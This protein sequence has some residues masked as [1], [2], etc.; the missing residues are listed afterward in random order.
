M[1]CLLFLYV[2]ILI[3]SYLLSSKNFNPKWNVRDDT[4]D[5]RSYDSNQVF[6]YEIVDNYPL[7]PRGRTG[8]RGRGRL[9]RWGPNHAADAVVTR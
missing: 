1:N 5:R 2:S 4:V 9:G 3:T 8:L 7:N 6:K